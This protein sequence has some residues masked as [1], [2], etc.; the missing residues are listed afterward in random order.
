MEKGNLVGRSGLDRRRLESI[1]LSAI[2]SK[3]LAIL[4]NGR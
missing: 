4:A 2:E 1:L 3:R